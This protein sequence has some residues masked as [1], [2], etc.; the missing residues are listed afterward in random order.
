[1]TYLSDGSVS[2]C[3]CELREIVFGNPNRLMMSEMKMLRERLGIM[4]TPYLV[5]ITSYKGTGRLSSLWHAQTKRIM[6]TIRAGILTPADD[7]RKR[8][9]IEE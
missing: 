4:T 2:S 5:G 7:I 3:A 6:D 9:A 8:K 1:M